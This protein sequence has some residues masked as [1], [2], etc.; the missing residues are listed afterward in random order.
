MVKLKI[1]LLI[2]VVLGVVLVIFFFKIKVVYGKY[3]KF[4]VDVVGKIFRVI[5]DF[6]IFGYYVLWK[7][8]FLGFGLFFV[9]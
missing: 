1:K 9:V 8:V 4:Y 3:V 5:K 2:V 7:Y 6:Y